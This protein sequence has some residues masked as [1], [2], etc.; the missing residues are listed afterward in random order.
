MVRRRKPPETHDLRSRHDFDEPDDDDFV[1][2][3]TET[4]LVDLTPEERQ[5]RAFSLA[6]VA[7]NILDLEAERTEVAKDFNAR[8]K[9]LKK[10]QRDLIEAVNTGAERRPRQL[11]L[12][13]DGGSPDA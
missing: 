6:E 8:L 12:V 10:Q 2:E 1:A 3:E 11:E 13:E 9:K 7:K 4:I 5:A